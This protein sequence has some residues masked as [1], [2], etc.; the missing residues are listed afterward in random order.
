MKGPNVTRDL[1]QS[2]PATILA[3]VE[4]VIAKTD[5]IGQKRRTACA[6][7]RSAAFLRHANEAR[8]LAVSEDLLA[9]AQALIAWGVM[10]RQALPLRGWLINRFRTPGGRCQSLSVIRLER[11]LAKSEGFP[12]GQLTTELE[13]ELDEEE[14]LFRY[15]AW[16]DGFRVT[17]DAVLNTANSLYTTLHPDALGPI[18]RLVADGEV[19]RNIELGLDRLVE[20]YRDR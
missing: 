13:L 2:L 3:A 17:G 8:A 6:T 16:F 4:R 19:W 14:G 20:A 7:Y 11:T 18:Y 10:V 5:D 1:P 12:G 15:R 9:K